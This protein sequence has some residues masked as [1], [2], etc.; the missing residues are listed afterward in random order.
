VWFVKTA[1]GTLQHSIPQ[2][3]KTGSATERLQRPKPEKSFI[4]AALFI[5]FFFRKPEI[6][7]EKRPQTA[8]SQRFNP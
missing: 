4:T 3:D 6:Y 8:F 7:R 5:F 2:T 1:V